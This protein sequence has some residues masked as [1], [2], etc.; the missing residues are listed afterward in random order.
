MRFELE[1][2]FE[3]SKDME[4]NKKLVAEV[5]EKA[6]KELLKRGAPKG[7]EDEAASIEKWSISGDR[8]TLLIKS[9][10]HVRATSALLRLRNQFNLLGE[11]TKAGIRKIEIKK[12]VVDGIELKKKPAA[13]VKISF[14]VDE[15]EI[16]GDK[17]K[18]RISNSISIDAIEKGAVDRIIELVNEK[19]ERQGYEGKEEIKKLL[20]SSKEKKV[21][22][23]EDPSVELEK[24]DWIRRTGAKGQFVY[25]TNFTSLVNAFKSILI[26]YIYKPLKFREMI[27]PKFEPWEVP[28]KS[29]H[30]KSIYPDAYYVMVPKV[31]SP[32]E[33][34]ASMDYF[35]ITGEVNKELIMDK[36]DSIGILSYAQC[37]PFWQY[38]E[39]RTV[40]DSSLPIK[41][42]DWSG[43]TYRNEAGGTHG[44]ARVEEF[45]RIE[46][47][48]VGYPEQVRDIGKKVE[49]K[50]GY[51]FDEVLGIEMKKYSVVPWWM[52]QEGEKE[53]KESSEGIGTV[54]FEAY[55]PYKGKREKS[56]WLEVQNV[57]IIGDKYPKAFS[58]KGRKPELWSGC[59]GGS[60]QRWICAFL[61]QKGFD[62]K[63][64]PEEVKKRVK[65][66]EEVRFA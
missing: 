31:S 51:I 54:D 46:T 48:F 25:G 57:S 62:L 16:K 27:F 6:D 59:A 13:P 36:V 7:M 61:A 12:L 64:W 43:P 20:W 17:A 22:Y 55:M 53:L 35:K 58:V 10:R 47:L 41:V 40:D 21:L 29:G 15:L 26:D 9:G 44:I 3:F 5:L 18:I 45:H 24:K 38:L 66:G 52:A 28:K 37:P 39:G 65:L 11:K 4:E 30:A 19:I 8:L 34:E 14:F 56:E 32:K 42:Y 33:W 50:L 1:A 2:V 63:N 49:E 60:F 23:E